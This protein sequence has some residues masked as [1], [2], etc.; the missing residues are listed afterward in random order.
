MA[1]A[2]AVVK[3][4]LLHLGINRVSRAFLPSYCYDLRQYQPCTDTSFLV[5][6]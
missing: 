6:V 5:R 4:I 1:S 3:Q 2:H